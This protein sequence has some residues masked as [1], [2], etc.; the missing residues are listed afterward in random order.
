[1]KKIAILASGGSTGG[2]SGFEKLV[3]ASLRGDLGTEVSCVLSNHKNGGVFERAHRLGVRF[4]HFDRPWTAERCYALIGENVDLICMSG[5]LKCLTGLDPI[6]TINIHPG[7]LPDFGGA[8]MYGHH[9]HE[10]VMKAY[11]EGRVTHSA[12]SMHFVT[13]EYDKG[14]VFFRFPIEIQ[15]DDTPDSLGSRVNA[16]EHEQQRRL[17]QRVL[18]GSISWDGTDPNSLVI[19]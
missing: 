18:E 8:G 12:V 7:P 15:K 9:V 2:G 14:P 5:W 17:T 10:A 16:A 19:A 11:R 6:R 3:E 1:M 4:E 13:D